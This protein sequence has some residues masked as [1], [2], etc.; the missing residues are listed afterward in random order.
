[1]SASTDFRIKQRLVIQFL[2]LEGCA[3]IEIHKH[4]K[5][6]YGDGC[7]DVKNVRKWV[8]RDNSCCAGEMSVS[9]EHR[10]GRPISVTCDENKCRVDAMI[11]ENRRIKP[12]D[13]A[14]KLCISQERVHLIIETLNYRKVC[15][16]WVPRQLT[17]LM[18][19]HKKTVA[20]ELLNWYHLEGDD[21]LKNITTGDESWIHHYDPENKRQSMEYRHPG[22]PSVKKFKTVPS[23]KKSCSPAFGMRGAC[24]TRNF[25][26]S[27]RRWIPT[28]IVQ[29]Y[30]HSS[31]ASAKSGR[32]ETR[33]FCITTTQ[34]HIAMHKFWTLW[35]A[36]TSHWLHS[37]LTVQIWHRQT[38]D[39]SQN[40]RRR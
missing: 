27:D 35:Q 17:D 24:F 22:S 20:Q 32:K 29:P 9:D 37:L 1:M 28:G 19:G 23:T 13:I 7:M 21:F 38:S 11:Q 30:N 2:T 6:V 33:F 25:W 26:L 36:S 18:K 12:R 31:N 40:W 39:C 16:R 3:A 8:R 10:P 14:L 15:A 5:A 4:M 34:G